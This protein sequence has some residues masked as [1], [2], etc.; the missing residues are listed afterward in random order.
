M[1]SGTAT[2]FS[3]MQDIN[4]GLTAG[5]VPLERVPELLPEGGLRELASAGRRMP[6]AE[7]K[8]VGLVNEVFADHAALLDGVREVAGTIASKSPLA[9]YGS[10]QMIT[11]ARDNSTADSLDHM[12]TWQAG[13]FQPA[14]MAEA[15]AAQAEGREGDFDDLLPFRGGLA[16]GV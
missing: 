7:A 5:G 2:A 9:V 8:A 6:A 10:K 1:W 12:A 16:D 4:I 15:F 11:Y 3:V 13:M 14:D